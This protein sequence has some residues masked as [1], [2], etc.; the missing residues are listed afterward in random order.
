MSDIYDLVVK[1]FGDLKPADYV[2]L[3]IFA[4]LIGVL[5]FR[6]IRTMYREPLEAHQAATAGWRETVEAHQASAEGWRDASQAYKEQIDGLRDQAA[7][8]E[9]HID[10]AREEFVGRERELMKGAF[11]LMV[12][13]TYYGLISS[14]KSQLIIYMGME[15]NLKDPAA[16]APIDLF[17]EIGEV[18]AQVDA[19]KEIAQRDLMDERFTV[20][21]ELREAIDPGPEDELTAVRD[22]MNPIFERWFNETTELQPGQ[23]AIEE[24]SS[25]R[26]RPPSLS[27]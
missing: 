14:L 4:V 27:S 3:V 7:E 23:R 17:H 22:R 16:P 18:E 11:V 24:N 26:T 6:W 25:S 5:L 15:L 8:L 1:H 20:S 2:I 10:Q 9:R 12:I 13:A 19:I 21:P